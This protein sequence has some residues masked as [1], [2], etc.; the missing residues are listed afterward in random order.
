MMPS[1]LLSTVRLVSVTLPVDGAETIGTTDPSLL[2]A[3]ALRGMVLVPF[4]KIEP[5]ALI[6]AV[7]AMLIEPTLLEAT[8]LS[9]PD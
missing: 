6:A 2:V 1:L 9:P 4:I 8:K 3:V 7:P 5:G